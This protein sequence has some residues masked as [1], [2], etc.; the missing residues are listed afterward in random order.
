MKHLATYIWENQISIK[1]TALDL[2]ISEEK[3]RGES[4]ENLTAGEFL[5][6]CNYLGIRPEKFRHEEV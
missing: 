3:L 1:Q 5:E 2:S 6:L 4:E